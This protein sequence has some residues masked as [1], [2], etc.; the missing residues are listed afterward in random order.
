MK[1]LN[2]NNANIKKILNKK[3]AIVCD[4]KEKELDFRKW[5]KQ[6]INAV[7]ED[8]VY[9]NCG[10]GICICLDY[11]GLKWDWTKYFLED[12]Y[13]IYEWEMAE[14]IK[15]ETVRMKKL[16]RNN[17]NIEKLRDKKVAV[18]LVGQ[19]AEID[20]R[21]WLEEN[22]IHFN[23]KEVLLIRN[24]IRT[25][26]CYCVEGNSWDW[27]DEKWFVEKGYSL[28]EW[29]I[30]EEE[31]TYTKKI[32]DAKPLTEEKKEILKS[33]LPQKTYTIKDVVE[34]EGKVYKCITDCNSGILYK[35]IDD[36]LYAT[37]KYRIE[38][39]KSLVGLRK[40]LKYEFIE[41]EPEP[42]EIIT[43]EEALK[44]METKVCRSMFSNRLITTY[45]SHFV[46]CINGEY[47]NLSMAEITGDWVVI[48]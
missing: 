9:T 7:D 31:N 16:N 24:G 10:N 38:W 25:E 29:E 15:S 44:E 22:G 21:K 1:K 19:D 30:A 36:V 45:D 43:F 20:F 14:V 40:L 18:R 33:C 13:S 26:I 4:S 46:D 12:N 5:A 47:T 6:Y 41:Y 8:Y 32:K 42:K 48:E 39:K 23:N 35:Y 3:V 17:A 37:P 11:D 28:Y 27:C 34:N 2:R